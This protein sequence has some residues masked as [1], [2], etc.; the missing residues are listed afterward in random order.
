MD[1]NY[2][3]EMR[4]SG[5]RWNHNGNPIEPFE[6]FARQGVERVRIR[7]WTGDTGVNGLR[8]AT[9]TARSAQEAGLEPYVVLF[10]SDDW[11][12]YV[13]QP[14]PERWEGLSLS[15]QTDAV[16][17]YAE[18]VARHFREE[19]IKVVFY[20]IGNE[21]DFGISGQFEKRW[22][23]RFNLGWMKQEIWPRAARIIDAA[24][25]GIRNV[26]PE[27][28]FLLHLTQWWNPNFIEKF[29]R[30]MTDEGVSVDRIGLAYF[31]TA[32]LG[33]GN[34]FRELGV[35]VEQLTAEIDRPVV[36]AETAYPSTGEIEGQFADWDQPV[37]GYPL[38]PSGQKQWVHDFIG[39][40]QN[41]SKIVEAYYWSPEWY[42]GP[43]WTA[44]SL[45]D[46]SGHS[47]PA[48]EALGR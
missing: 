14:V 11:A 13:K 30:T 3:L 24:Q 26:E 5:H 18:R 4:R 7:L 17:R 29:F 9:E 43:L 1:A 19:G 41:Q 16:E 22:S 37:P 35:A 48:L 8:Y 20:E 32:D 42:V 38:T 25:T 15:K 34:R 39:F 12:D 28:T 33:D 46:E 2:W 6:Q 21:I 36:I 31:P 45:F 23:H 27:A 44:F 40:T 47:K 10:L